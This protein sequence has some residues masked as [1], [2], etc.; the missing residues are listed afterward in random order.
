MNVVIINF[1][2]C[3][4][5]FLQFFLIKYQRHDVNHFQRCLT[6]EINFINFIVRIDRFFV[7]ID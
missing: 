4:L 1:V 6:V 7:M 5:Y 3:R 2:R